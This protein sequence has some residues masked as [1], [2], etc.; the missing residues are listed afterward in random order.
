[1]WKISES[2]IRAPS[3]EFYVP[4]DLEFPY[5]VFTETTSVRAGV[6]LRTQRSR[7]FFAVLNDQ[8]ELSVTKYGD[9]TAVH[10]I[11]EKF[12]NFPVDKEA[13]ISELQKIESVVKR[14]AAA[15]F[16]RIGQS[17]LCP[18]LAVS[19]ARHGFSLC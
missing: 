2:P 5:D 13:S 12:L 11:S 7:D 9:C 16:L 17:L 3:L 8:F 4:G 6:S 14:V 1:M 15:T 10:F 19:G 18:R